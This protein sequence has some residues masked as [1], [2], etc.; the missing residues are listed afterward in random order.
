MGVE[1][2]KTQDYHDKYT[3]PDQFVDMYLYLL[4][5]FLCWNAIMLLP[6]LRRSEGHGAGS[7][8][9]CRVRWI[10]GEAFLGLAGG[11]NLTPLQEFS[12]NPG[13]TFGS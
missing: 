1:I 3:S 9:L 11:L 2:L 10:C 4:I 5:V 8:R 12:G 13:T 7:V 6:F